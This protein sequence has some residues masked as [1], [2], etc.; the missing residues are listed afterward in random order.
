MFAQ[1]R[2]KEWILLPHAVRVVHD[3]NYSVD[4]RT[5][6]GVV[7][8]GGGTGIRSG[9]GGK[10]GYDDV[11]SSSSSSSRGS[12]KDSHAGIANLFRIKGGRFAAP[13]VFGSGSSAMLV[14]RGVAGANAQLGAGRALPPA[15]NVTVL[16][17]GSGSH[18]TQLNYTTATVGG[19]AE[20]SISVP[21]V[22]GCAM[23]LVG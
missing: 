11:N 19:W 1:L 5:K 15:L 23:V 14:L 18:A 8:G 2:S 22:R 16:H 7:N 20:V 9:G 21:L 13:I 6:D 3:L 10:G 12:S 4:T 17:P